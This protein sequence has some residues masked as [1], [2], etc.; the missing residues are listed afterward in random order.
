[1]RDYFREE[2]RDLERVYFEFQGGR[3]EGDGFLLWNPQDGF[4]IEARVERY[5]PPPPETIEV[6]AVNVPKDSDYAVIR[7]KLGRDD[8]AITQVRLELPWITPHGKW[9]SIATSRVIFFLSDQWAKPSDRYCGSALYAIQDGL[10]LPHGL[11]SET[12]LQGQTIESGSSK[13]GILHEADN[14]FRLMGRITDDEKTFRCD[15]RLPKTEWQRSD[16]YRWARAIRDSMSILAKQTV[17]LLQ[18]E[19]FVGRRYRVEK[20]KQVSGEKLGFCAPFHDDFVDPIRLVGLAEFLSRGGLKAGICSHVLRRLA[21][22]ARQAEWAD[23]ELLVGTTLEAILRTL[24]GFPYTNRRS[25]KIK[26]CL[27]R[28]RE[29]YLSDEWIPRCEMAL[30]SRDLTRNRNAHLEW[31][32]EPGGSLSRE[33]MVKSVDAIIFLAHFYGYM[34]LALAGFKD[35]EP[36]FPAPHEKWGPMLT[37]HSGPKEKQQ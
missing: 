23:K 26:Q 7:M 8:F 34:I 9:V 22:A 35:I 25:F 29:E 14:G 1:M 12:R 11:E 21:E 19:A 36:K 30:H 5:G 2:R 3:Y 27:E 28:F 13:R 18:S 17:A 20:R 16:N 10:L 32:S 24:Y 4:T 33:E 31:I 6:R 37:Y 15:W